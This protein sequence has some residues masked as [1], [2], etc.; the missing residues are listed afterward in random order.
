MSR[1]LIIVPE[2]LSKVR[3]VGVNPYIDLGTAQNKLITK[4]RFVPVV[5]KLNKHA[6]LA[7]LV[8]LGKGKFRLY[9]HG[10]IRKKTNVEVGDTVTISL[11]EDTK[12]RTENILELLSAELKND[13]LMKTNWDKL[14]P[15]RQKEIC[16]YL[17]NLKTQ[18]SMEKNISKVVRMLTKHP[19]EKLA[20]ISIAKQTTCVLCLL[21]V[22]SIAIYGCAKKKTTEKIYSESTSTSLYLYKGKDTIY[23][24]AGTSPH[25]NFNLNFNQT[26]HDAFGVDG[27]LPVG[28]TFPEGSLIV[29]EIYDANNQLIVYAV[30]KKDRKSKFAN[31]KWIWAEYNADGSSKVSI[32]REGKD[33]VDCHTSGITRDLTLSFDLH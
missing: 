8:P 27:K 3:I 21:T 10:I 5:A 15:S 24:P 12:P 2:F 25:G 4:K 32:A 11:K 28:Q 31:H 13:A 16:R 30:M 33:C 6:F 29:K 14:S 23:H 18:Q 9:L 19:K 1:S 26:P 17:N 7:N 22:M 20:G